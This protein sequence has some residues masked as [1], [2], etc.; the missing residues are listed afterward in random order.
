MFDFIKSIIEE[1]ADVGCYEY[2]QTGPHSDSN[3]PK[4]RQPECGP[5]TKK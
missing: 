2:I 3:T 5:Q 1:Y 4:N